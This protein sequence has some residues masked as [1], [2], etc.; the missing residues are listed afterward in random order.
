M[1]SIAY[2]PHQHI[3]ATLK[4]NV[5]EENKIWLKFSLSLTFTDLLSINWLHDRHYLTI[6]NVFQFYKFDWQIDVST[7]DSYNDRLRAL[8]AVTW[9]TWVRGASLALALDLKYFLP[10]TQKGRVWKSKFLGCCRK[11]WSFINFDAIVSLN[12][13][14]SLLSWHSST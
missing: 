9:H 10:L 14:F 13:S 3:N 5:L 7:S 6:S 2:N 11:R 1:H 8:E 4:N 12:L